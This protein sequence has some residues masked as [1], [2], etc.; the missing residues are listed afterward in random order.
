MHLQKTFLL[1][2]AHILIIFFRIYKIFCLWVLNLPR[3]LLHMTRLERNR[4]ILILLFPY[5]IW[6]F[7][8]HSSTL[9]TVL[10]QNLK[11]PH[12]VNNLAAVFCIYIPQQPHLSISWP[13]GL[14]DLFTYLLIPWSKVLEKPTGS[15]LV[16]KFP[17]F[18]GTLRFITAFTKARQLSLYWAR[19][20]QSM[21]PSHFRKINLNIIRPSTPE[22]F[23]WSLSLIFPHQKSVCTSPLPHTCYNT[24][25]QNILEDSTLICDQSVTTQNV[26]FFELLV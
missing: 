7:A 10:V 14:T 16:K 3:A 1:A 19:S 26:T 9:A 13:A 21:P 4:H 22:S 18:H 17:A 6:M 5:E 15:Q 24:R 20:N 25:N 8:E 2:S 23:K 12:L 11:V